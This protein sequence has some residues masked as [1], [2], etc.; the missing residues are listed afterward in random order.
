MKDIS[1]YSLETAPPLYTPFAAGRYTTG[2]AMRTLGFDFGN[3]AADRLSIQIDAQYRHYRA[4]KL[5]CRRP[6]DHIDRYYAR[7]TGNEDIQ[8]ALAVWLAGRLAT[9]YPE[10][11]YYK[12][13]DHQHSLR[14]DL[15]N[16]TIVWND[17][18]DLLPASALHFEAVDLCDALMMQI[19]EDVAVT[20][21]TADRN[22]TQALIHLCAPNHWA[23]GD[24][25]GRSF[26]GVHDVVPGAELDKLKDRYTDFLYRCC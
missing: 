2:P 11:F 16:E 20:R 4:N 12:Y 14:N 8:P 22:D 9:E 26:A 23:P 13:A 18:G 19:P 24:K 17:A 6:P 5:A 7:D 25:I 21:F 1:S 15:M 3:G 10:F